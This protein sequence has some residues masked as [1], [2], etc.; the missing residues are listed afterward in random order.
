MSDELLLQQFDALVNGTISE[1]DHRE[2]QERLKS[3]VVAR[4]LFRERMDLE[5]GLRTWAADSLID[6]QSGENRVLGTHRPR[7]HRS[8]W[9][10]TL[11][12]TAASIMVIAFWWVHYNYFRR[13]GYIDNWIIAL[14]A[15]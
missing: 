11:L 4:T 8:H 9:S 1:A 5:A 15:F 7:Q 6:E 3:D 14:N 2:L 12:A 10:I 13:T